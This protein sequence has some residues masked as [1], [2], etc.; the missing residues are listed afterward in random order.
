MPY[1]NNKGAG[2]PVHPQSDQCLC[3]LLPKQY[4]HILLNPKF[5]DSEQAGLSRTRSQISRKQVF[6]VTWFI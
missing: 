1:A 6:L 5:Q 2:Q 3:C 4:K